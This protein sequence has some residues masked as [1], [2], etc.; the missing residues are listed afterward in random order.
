M[1]NKMVLKTGVHVER[2]REKESGWKKTGKRLW[3]KECKSS[4]RDKDEE[5]GHIN[6]SDRSEG[7]RLRG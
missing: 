6:K 2:E 5:A 7:R 3:R 1:K 4:W